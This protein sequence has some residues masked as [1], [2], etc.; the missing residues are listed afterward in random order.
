MKKDLLKYGAVLGVASMAFVAGSTG[1]A[2]ADHLIGSSQI[3]NN[4]ITGADLSP[5][6]VGFSELAPSSVGWSN[7]GAGLQQSLRGNTGPKG[8][9]GATGPAGPAGAKGDKGDTGATGTNGL[10]SAYYA[11]AFYDAGNTNSGAIATVA[12]RATTDVAI[13]GGV[14]ILGIGADQS[15]INAANARNTPVSSSF[16]G[17]MDWATYSPLPNRLDGWIVQFGGGTIAPLKAKVWALCVPGAN[18]S[19][20]NTYTESAD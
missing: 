11:T 1:G 19:V 9:P 14:Q 16:P 3:R 5:D 8:D 10:V 2:V 17:R 13:S 18:V 12:C 6:S 4:S 20:Q 7:L 15:E